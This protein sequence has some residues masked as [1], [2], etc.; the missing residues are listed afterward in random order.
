MAWPGRPP[1]R[2]CRSPTGCAGGRPTEPA[3]QNR[4]AGALQGPATRLRAWVALR[5]HAYRIRPEAGPEN[6][7]LGRERQGPA[8]AWAVP[9]CRAAGRRVRLEEASQVAANRA[10]PGMATPAE[11]RTATVSL[12]QAIPAQGNPARASRVRL[13]PVPA[14]S[15]RSVDL[16]LRLA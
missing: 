2:E 10:E 12:A 7:A 9:D 5:G 13:R 15:S 14:T 6:R 4:S 8:R 16:R 11:R 1:V 3:C